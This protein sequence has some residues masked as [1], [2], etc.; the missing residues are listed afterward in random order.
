MAAMAT[1]T[2]DCG[3]FLTTDNPQAEILLVDSSFQVIARGLSPLIGRAP[4]GF[5]AMKTKVGDEENESLF[6]LEPGGAVLNKKLKAPEF[7]SPIPLLETST[8]HEYHRAAVDQFLQGF[9]SLDGPLDLGRG[10]TVV[11][12]VRDPSGANFAAELGVS[13]TKRAEYANSFTGFR[14]L[15]AAGE[16]LANLDE[17]AVHRLDAGFM[18][19]TVH[20]DPGMYSL[21]YGRGDDWICLALPA[22]TGWT[23]QVY[24]N[25]ISAGKSPFDLVPD[26]ADIAVLFDRTSIGFD[27]G[28]QDLLVGETI[29]K[30]LLDGRNYVGP[31]DM[32]MLLSEKFANP[33]LGLYAAHLMLLEPSP[34]FKL[35]RTVIHNTTLMLGEDFPDVFAL[36]W[37]FEHRMEAESIK[38]EMPKHSAQLPK[39]S[40]PPILTRSWDLLL[41]AAKDS[42][43]N[44]LSNSPAF[45]MA[46]DLLAQGIFV[47]WRRRAPTQGK[48]DWVSTVGLGA[49]ASE[50]RVFA[51][52]PQTDWVS[53]LASLSKPLRSF[54]SL[55]AIFRRKA[56]PEG[57]QNL[58]SQIVDV[59]SAGDAAKLM[60]RLAER[61]D[62]Q[63]LLSWLRNNPELLARLSGF[64][65]DLLL[66]LRDASISIP[67]LEALT[68]GFV[69]RLLDDHRIPLS[70]LL[71]GLEKATEAVSTISQLLLQIVPDGREG[72]PNA[73]DA[74]TDEEGDQDKPT[75]V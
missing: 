12:C 2:S 61:Y 60:Q 6:A 22:V 16:T 74:P 13:N 53:A 42:Q 37:A 10:A 44:E 18:G 40:G 39:L 65:R 26:L 50:L 30:G 68:A 31:S 14:I 23:F 57:E 73:P 59:R 11:I 20:L 15:D 5:Y 8:T 41:Q 58:V 48:V 55:A 36:R 54:V 34:N 49:S 9:G 38:L 24:V 64:Q 63:A 75:A 3:F 21:G 32:H 51:A 7:E 17:K 71:D 33:I 28:R 35:L 67:G 27:A 19:I 70:T 52:D 66:M 4:P 25:L 47:T 45:A 62:W 29:R 1:S 43:V 69:E 56:A 46:G 72:H